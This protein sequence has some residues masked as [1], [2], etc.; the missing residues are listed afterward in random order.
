MD[1]STFF[2]IAVIDSVLKDVLW[3]PFVEENDGPFLVIQATPEQQN[4]DEDLKKRADFWKA[5]FEDLPPIFTSEA[6]AEEPIIHSK[7]F[8]R[9]FKIIK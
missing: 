7:S 6:A 1:K 9:R 3:T 8:R 4:Y 5:I 2:I